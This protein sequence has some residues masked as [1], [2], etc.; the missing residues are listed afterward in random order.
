MKKALLILSA[1]LMYL[2]VSAQHWTDV[3]GKR[4]KLEDIRIEQEKRLQQTAEE[5]KAEKKQS[6]K[7]IRE[8]KNYHFSRWL[9]YWEDHLDEEGYMVSPV[10]TLVE[11][12]AFRNRQQVRRM[13]KTTL[14]QS[15]WTFTG[16]TSS[17]GGYR[18]LGR[19]NVIEFHPTNPAIF[20]IG[21]A[22][23]GAW[24][25]T[26]GGV[27]WSS[28]YDNLPVLG[29]SDIDYNP[30]DPNT[31]YLCTGDRDASDTYSVGILKSMDGGATW[32][33]TGLQYGITDF[34]LTNELLINPHDSNSMLVATNSGM[35]KSTD[36]GA[37]WTQVASGHIK[38]IVY[39]ATDTN[40]IFAATYGGNN[41]ILRS[42]DA[43]MT[44]TQVSN[45]S[46]ARRIALAVTPA[47]PNQVVAVVA[48]S[49]EALKGVYKSTNGG[50]NFTKVFGD[51]NDCSTNILSTWLTLDGGTCSGQAWYDLCIT[52]NPV[53]P[54]EMLIGSVNTYHTMDGGASWDMVTQWYGG[55]PG[56]EEVHADKHF[57]SFHPLTPSVLF[58]GNDGGIYK[59]SNPAGGVWNDLSNGLGITQFYRI[60]G[61]DAA[62]FVIGG[63]QDN[64]TKRISFTGVFSELTGG[65]GMDCQIDYLTP[66]T[67]YTS[68]QY[69]NLNRTTNNGI[70]YNSISDNIPDNPEGAWI[71]PIVLHPNDPNFILAGYDHVYASFD[72]GDSWSDISPNFPTS[73]TKL[74][75]LAMTH[76]DQQVIFAMGGNNTLKYTSDF[77]ANWLN[78]PGG[79]AGSIS[80]ITIDPWNKDLLWITY[81]GYG[82]A[83]VAN[84]NTQTGWSLKNDSLPNIPV[85]CIA[86]DSSN[87]TRY[88]GTDIG[89]FYRDTSMNSWQTFANGLPTIEVTDLSINYATDEI[90]AAT[91]GRGMWKSPRHLTNPPISA[92]NPIPYAAD[93]ITISPNPNQ[94][95]FEISTTNSSLL[96][97]EVE[98]H[99][100]S[101]NGAVVSKLKTSF[102]NSGRLQIHAD[103]LSRGTYITDVYHN[104]VRAAKTKMV[105]L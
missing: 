63:S 2:P 56:I 1:G 59:T 31:I 64:G 87:G 68:S 98:V 103:K 3:P 81:S 25:T 86:I 42:A 10:K 21:S 28:L 44:W 19:I 4:M 65:D 50:L 33:T 101:L 36:A 95:Q 41:K 82:N 100:I 60:A 22:G 48:N 38:D 72:Q 75:R 96:G 53:N 58:E 57:L 23:G 6:G 84:F 83:K 104:G 39:H 47:D 51:E 37:S 73:G 61:A 85:R 55:L 77:G 76:L 13:A 17:P 79:Y 9:N 16:P 99:I 40:I 20:I 14:D 29:V 15:Q 92:V 70:S 62:P 80:D 32:D 105:V 27:S 30:Q 26:N 46:G 67:F 88:I 90:W 94:G 18:G 45:F 74:E 34:A 93:V 24:R 78:V 8:G 5:K 97:Q 12:K 71:T 91:Y 102:S 11:L 49:D 66:T 52:V 35:M 69:G 7:I 89:V 54:N 43:G